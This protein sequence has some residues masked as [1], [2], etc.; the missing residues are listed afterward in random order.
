MGDETDGIEGVRA[1]GKTV[2]RVETA[3]ERF[4][5]QMTSVEMLFQILVNRL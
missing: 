2:S 3:G 1:Q 4:L 5:F